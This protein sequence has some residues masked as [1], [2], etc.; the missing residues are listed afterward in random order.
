V[1]DLTRSW[2]LYLG[3][4]ECETCGGSGEALSVELF[5]GQAE[6]RYTVGC[7]G[8]DSK[9]GTPADVAAWL[10]DL[11][12]SHSDLLADRADDVRVIAEELARLTPTL[13]TEPTPEG[14]PA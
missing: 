5:D 11:V 12:A 1:S 13:S 4:S 7:F 9:S 3:Y 8:G 10:L 14:T 2:E 6:A